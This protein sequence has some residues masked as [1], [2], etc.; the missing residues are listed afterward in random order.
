AQN[1]VLADFWRELATINGK[2]SALGNFE[3]FTGSFENLFSLPEDINVIT[4]EQVR[5]AAARVFRN[6]NMTVGILRA[7]G[8][9]PEAAE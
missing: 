2:A 5:A 6:T 1:I 8:Y 3:V 7:P 4:P 9:V